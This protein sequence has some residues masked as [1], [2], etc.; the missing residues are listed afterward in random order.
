MCPRVL[1][2]ALIALILASPIFALP[3]SPNDQFRALSLRAPRRPEPPICCLK[4]LPPLEVVEEEV[5]LSFEEWKA[6]QRLTQ[7]Q[8]R[9]DSGNRSGSASGFGGNGSSGGGEGVGSEGV[10]LTS[11]IPPS[12][13]LGSSPTLEEPENSFEALSP[14]FRVPL[15]DRFNYASLDCSARVHTA[16]KSAK[17]PSSI[18]I[19]K[20]DRYMLSPCVSKGEKQFVVIELCE[21]IRLDTVQL[22][23]FEFFSGVFKDFTVSVAKTYTTDAEGWIAAGTYRAKNVRGVQV[24]LPMSLAP[25]H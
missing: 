20:R 16:H 21:D 10:N 2:I 7:T 19:S 24:S 8:E 3:T 4:P 6:K 18:L 23:N 5:L 13:D 9:K 1:P 15:T 17:S 11:D 12:H 25:P 14:H 22:A